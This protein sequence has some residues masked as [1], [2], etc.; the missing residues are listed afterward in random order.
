MPSALRATADRLLAAK[1]AK[2]AS[3]F[4]KHPMFSHPVASASRPKI[5]SVSPGAVVGGV[6]GAHG[7]HRAGGGVG[8]SVAGGLVGTLVGDAVYQAIAAAI[9][10][11][12]D[13]ETRKMAVPLALLASVIAGQVSGSVTKKWLV[14]DAKKKEN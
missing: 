2:T 13:I 5:A 6:G 14:G 3:A 4:G 10:Q 1:A 11:H 9:L 8:S 7:A 12:K